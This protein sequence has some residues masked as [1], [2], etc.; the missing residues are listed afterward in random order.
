MNPLTF[1]DGVRV[2]ARDPARG[3][4]NKIGKTSIPPDVL[5]TYQE[6]LDGLRPEGMVIIKVEFEEGGDGLFYASK[7]Q[8]FEPAQL[9]LFEL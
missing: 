7:L 6:Y 5:W 8:L 2:I 1:K 4:P 3:Y 9:E